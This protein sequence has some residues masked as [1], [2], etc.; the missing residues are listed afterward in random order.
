CPTRWDSHGVSRDEAMASGLVPVTNRVAAIPEFVDDACG[1]LADPE[2]A[3]GLA[4]GIARLYSDPSAFEALS[5]AAHQRVMSRSS[6]GIGSREM[7][8]FRS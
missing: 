8:L 2:D 1:I 4:A 5:L 7:E 6:D 3:A